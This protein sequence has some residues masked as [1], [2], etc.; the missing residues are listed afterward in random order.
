MNRRLQEFGRW[1]GIIGAIIVLI[2]ILFGLRWF[3]GD[4][5]IWFR[6]K[7]NAL[8]YSDLRIVKY[9]DGYSGKWNVPND[10]SIRAIAVSNTVPVAAMD[11]SGLLFPL[12]EADRKGFDKVDW[13]YGWFRYCLTKWSEWIIA[14]LFGVG[15]LLCCVKLYIG[16]KRSK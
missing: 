5:L 4:D 6:L 8:G 7:L 9:T 14:I 10:L 3:A 1:W 13:T 2:G 11:R 16:R 12:S 15:V